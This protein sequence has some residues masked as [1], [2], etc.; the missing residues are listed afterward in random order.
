V[1]YH[2]D[3]DAAARLVSELGVRAA[4]FQADLSSYDGARAL[5]AAVVAALGHPDVL[6]NN[7]GVAGTRI[8]PQG[9]V[10]DLSVE[11]FERTWRTNTGTAYLVTR[12]DIFASRE[13]GR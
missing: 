11:E 6:Y 8:G 4:A 3:A 7:A 13:A 12:F 9:A 1:H 2:R 10:G 5:H